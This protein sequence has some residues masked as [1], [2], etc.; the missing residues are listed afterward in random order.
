MNS[1]ILG[2][3]NSKH[4]LVD[5]SYLVSLLDSYPQMAETAKLAM[6]IRPFGIQRVGD[7]AV[8]SI[9][10]L[11]MAELDFLSFILGASTFSEIQ[12]DL[13]EVGADT[14]I[15]SVL[16]D[17]SSPGGEVNGTA[18]TAEIVAELAKA[19][20]VVAFG[21]GHM[22]SAAY[23]VASSASR[24]VCSPTC[25]VGSVGTALEHIDQSRLDAALGLK[26]TELVSGQFKRLGTPHAPLSREARDY[27]QSQVND[28]NSVFLSTVQKNRNLGEEEM[29]E[30][31]EAKI[32]IGE[33]SRRVGL[34]DRIS[35][36]DKTLLSMQSQPDGT[37]ETIESTVVPVDNSQEVP[38]PEE[39]KTDSATQQ[40]ETQT[41]VSE[42]AQQPAANPAPQQTGEE[43]KRIKEILAL[44]QKTEMEAEA[45]RVAFDT[46]MTPSEAAMHLLNHPDYGK[47]QES[48]HQQQTTT[49]QQ[50][51]N[52]GLLSRYA[53]SFEKEGE[54]SAAE[55]TMPTGSDD[56][57]PWN[58]LMASAVDAH[59]KKVPGM[60]S[61]NGVPNV[62]TEDYMKRKMLAG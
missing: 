7:V 39:M 42:P 4:W 59:N 48:Q 22:T 62:A 38:M 53:E 23:W 6:P 1:D 61:A 14:E 2:L 19:K 21:S 45:Q 28:L 58:S 16:L 29:A 60:P 17:I 10:G 46:D 9:H 18:E 33:N 27:L 15:E 12:N 32:F 52:S 44:G 41:Q 11:L 26:Y 20:M 24:V 56:E 49:N 57:N 35:F 47:Q 3:I 43:R 50:Q 5:E 8:I 30:I 55:H 54:N 36:F 51:G 40:T 25:M 31:R 37:D 34:V 13:R